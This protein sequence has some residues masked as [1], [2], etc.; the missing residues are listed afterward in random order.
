M[1]SLSLATYLLLSAAVL[2]FVFFMHMEQKHSNSNKKNPE[3]KK[4]WKHNKDLLMA[5]GMF[6]IALLFAIVSLSFD[7]FG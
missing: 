2:S 7:I 1:L 6:I 5:L 3:Q 4:Q